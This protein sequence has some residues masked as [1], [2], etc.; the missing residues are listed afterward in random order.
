MTALTMLSDGIVEHGLKKKCI[1]LTQNVILIQIL[2]QQQERIE[3]NFVNS[4]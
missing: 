3:C 4:K 1:E 2:R